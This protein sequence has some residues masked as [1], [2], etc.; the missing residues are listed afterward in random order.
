MLS[1]Q[2]DYHCGNHADVLKH[3]V[4]TVCLTAMVRKDKPLRMLD[5]HAGSGIYDLR[6]QAAR[7]NAEFAEGIARVLATTGSPAALDP[8]LAVVRAL[9]PARGRL[10][11]YPG[12]PELARR[13]LRPD[14]QLELLELHPQAVAALRRQMGRDPR[15]HIHHRDSF[16]GL[17]ALLPPPERR[18]LVLIDPSYEVKDEFPRVVE[19]FKACHRRW[20]TG[21]YLAW[22]PLIR[23][24]QS[25]RFPAKL[26]AT[27]IRRIFQAELQVDADAVP[28][29]RGSG[30]MLVNPPFGV[31]DD[32]Q[33]LIPW[34]WESL[35]A[36][37]RGHWKAEWLVAE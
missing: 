17:P 34:L 4:L 10:Q 6:S 16:E 12:S 23:H 1:Y 5:A 21:V 29:L 31:A 25:E 32:L 11:R 30:V 24:P 13:L 2:H 3:A 7:K 15:V 22:Y 8:Y 27:G 33:E 26:R 18:G 35:A 20:P 37:R 14:D 28:G 9:N 19:L 36:D